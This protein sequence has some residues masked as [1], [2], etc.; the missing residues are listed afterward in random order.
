MDQALLIAIVAGGSAL[1][2]SLIT[3]II[4]LKTSVSQKKIESYK[5]RLIKS[6]QDIAA[7]HRLEEEYLGILESEEKWVLEGD[8]PKVVFNCGAVQRD[9]TYYVY[10]G[11]ADNVIAVATVGTAEA[12]DF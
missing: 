7:F 5:R 3:G 9:D 2:G 6:Y 11:G 1:G 8:V 10:Y 12:L 4:T